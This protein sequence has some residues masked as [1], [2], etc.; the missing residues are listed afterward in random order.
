[1]QITDAL[2]GQTVEDVRSFEDGSVSFYCSSGRVVSLAPENGEIRLKR[3]K[4]RLEGVDIPKPST[5]MNILE[6]FQGFTIEYAYYTEKGGIIFVCEPLLHN[7]PER[8]GQKSY[9]HREIE[10]D[11]VN[12]KIVDIPSVSAKV[13]LPSLSIMG[14]IVL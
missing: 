11:I 1:M 13:G 6:A 12:N 5:R 10:L 9:G 8:Y 3:E 4:I 14:E 2:N 7:R